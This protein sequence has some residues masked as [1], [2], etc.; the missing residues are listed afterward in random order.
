MRFRLTQHARRRMQQRSVTEDQVR[1]TLLSPDLT[2]EDTP[3]GSRAFHKDLGHGVLKV[4]VVWPP[5]S[6]D[7]WIVK[8]TAWKGVDDG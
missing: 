5:N 3:Q 2:Y 6:D 1:A 8:S 4:W 7:N